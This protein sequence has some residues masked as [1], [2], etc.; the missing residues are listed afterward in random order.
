MYFWQRCREFSGNEIH[1]NLHI[2][3]FT[4]IVQH[5]SKDKDGNEMRSNISI[6]K[7]DIILTCSCKT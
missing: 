6:M 1:R 3:Y 4:K 7:E 2:I 5:E